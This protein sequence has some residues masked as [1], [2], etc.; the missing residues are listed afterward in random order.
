MDFEIGYITAPLVMMALDVAFGYLSAMKNGSLNSSVMREGLWNKT[1]ELLIIAAG[2]GTQFSIS[3]FGES[4][5][6][7]TPNVPV[8]VGICA[9]VCVY[10]LTSIIENIG[11]FTPAIGEKFV[12]ILGIDP[13]KVGLIE[14]DVADSRNDAGSGADADGD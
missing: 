11:K 8:A 12:K 14:I 3:V 13:L 10:E 9:Y 1:L 5:L 2:F 4:Q 7:F 6:G